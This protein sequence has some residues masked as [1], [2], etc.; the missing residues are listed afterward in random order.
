M[1][2]PVI[3][4]FPDASVAVPEIVV[5]LAGDDTITPV[6]ENEL[7]GLTFRLDGGPDGATRYVKWA[8]PDTPELNLD[9]EARRLSWAQRWITV[10]RVIEHGIDDD[11]SWLVTLPVPGQSAVA[12]QWIVDPTSAATAVGRGL[13]MVHD[14]LPV[15]QCPFDWSVEQRLARARERLSD[16]E[17]LV[18]RLDPD[19]HPDVSDPNA[20]IAEPPPT[21]VAVVCHG[22]ACAPNTLLHDDGTFA[23]HVDLGSLGVADRWADLAVAAWSTVWNY[24]PGYE[25]IVYDAYGVD[26]DPERIA[27]YR[28]IWDIT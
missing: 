12:P 17:Q 25:E 18:D 28:L 23:A 24:G 14:T 21:D 9:D 11:G 20:L 2:R 8:P 6:W 3:S 13:R 7:G 10:P 15:E 16:G 19:Q 5:K 26:P 4:G 27:F 22:D 1:S